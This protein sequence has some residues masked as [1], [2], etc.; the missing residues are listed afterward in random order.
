MDLARVHEQNRLVLR[1]DR[2][3]EEYRVEIDVGAAEVEQ[4]CDFVEHVHDHRLEVFALEL[5]L[6]ALDLLSVGLACST[7]LS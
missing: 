3:R 1:H 4:P 5:L 2:I 6:K 7:R